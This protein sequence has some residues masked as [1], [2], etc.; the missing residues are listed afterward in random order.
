MI[1]VANK[2][3]TVEG[4]PWLRLFEER[5]RTQRSTRPPWLQQLRKA[6]IAHFAKL[7][8]PTT[9]DEDWRFTDLTALSQYPWELGSVQCSVLG[10]VDPEVGLRVPRFDGCCELV[11]IDGRYVSALSNHHESP[12]NLSVSNLAHGLSTLSSAESSHFGRVAR[13][14]VN[15]LASLNTALFEDGAFIVVPAN[16]VIKQPIHLVFL[17]TTGADQ[18]AFHPRHFIWVKAG[19]QAKVIEH[20][21]SLGETRHF[22]NAVTEIVLEEGAQLEH[23][24][25]QDESPRAYH[26]ALTECHQAR[27]SR[28]ISHSFSRGAKLA[29]HDLIAALNGEGAECRFNGLFL[30]GS[31]QLVDHHTLIEHNHPHCASHEDYHG[32]LDGQAQGVFNGKILVRKEAQKTDAKQS[33]RNL[34]LSE[35]ATIHSKPQLEIFADDVRCTHGATVGSLD[36]EALFYLRSR[37]LGL[38]ESRRLLIRAFASQILSRISVAPVR[39]ALDSFI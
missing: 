13:Y 7:G 22:T 18:A 25:I 4:A 30:G 19:G 17:T 34:L 23:S 2:K 36:K 31:H 9:A 1:D 6:G 28:L 15:G 12:L 11:F 29:R 3:V 35:N 27:G 21:L 26:I 5:E 39:A 32:I 14:C 20:Y 37:G 33:N 16:G 24:K 8:F 38:E 10:G